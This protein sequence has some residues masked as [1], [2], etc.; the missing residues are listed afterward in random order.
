MSSKR[1]SLGRNLSAL[2]SNT[3]PSMTQ[4]KSDKTHNLKYLPVSLLSRGKYQPRRAIENDAL[5]E[6]ADSIKQQGVIQPLVVRTTGPERYEIVAG[7]RRWRAA[8]LAGLTEVPVIV[9]DIPDE[10]AVAVALIEN[11]QRE[12]LNPMEEARALHRLLQEFE[13]THQQVAE[14]IGKSR[15][16]V[17]NFLRLISLA[18]EVKTLL[19]HGDLEM[20][21]AKA[22]LS[23][24][25]EVQCDIAR[26][27]AA[28][29]LSV[30]E[31]EN[32]VRSH[33]LLRIIVAGGVI[34]HH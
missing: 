11:I 23:L 15:A 29:G 28:N 34:R 22:M 17:T 6:L 30:R 7:E 4:A 31:T 33:G 32:I 14:A 20:G 13:L 19:E 21:H 24:P 10:Q 27:V 5:R 2:L 3:N 18:D 25:P 16:T 26:K 9:T 1:S 8:Q 12:D